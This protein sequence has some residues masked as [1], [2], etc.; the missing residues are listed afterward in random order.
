MKLF[1]FGDSICVGQNVSVEKI[2]VHTIAK[3]LSDCY[4]DILVMNPSISGNTTRMALERMYFDALSHKPDLL[5]IQFGLNDCNV[6]A[7]DA[8]CERVSPD[9]YIAN[10]SEMIHKAYAAGC[11]KVILNTNHP[12]G[13]NK[14]FLPN[15]DITY[16]ENNKLYYQRLCDF[17]RSRKDIVSLD[18]RGHM[19]SLSITPE[20]YL[21]E[22]GVHLNENGHE[23]YFKYIINFLKNVISEIYK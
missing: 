20:T 13:L 14:S 18:I 3:N 16:E 4:P 10:L 19:E 1:F 17:Q 2:W 12:S 9:A 5:Y 11:K 23:I 7:T 21:L 22:D 6:W 8:G 15:R